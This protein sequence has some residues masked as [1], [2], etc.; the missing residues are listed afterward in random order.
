MYMVKEKQSLHE[1]YQYFPNDL[2]LKSF[3]VLGL[4]VAV[5]VHAKHFCYN[6]LHRQV[7]TMCPRN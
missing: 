1:L 5:D 7:F 4:N 2:N 3:I 6:A